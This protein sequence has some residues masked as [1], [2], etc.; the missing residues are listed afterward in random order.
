M[1]AH[2]DRLKYCDAHGLLKYASPTHIQPECEHFL[3]VPWEYLHVFKAGGTTVQSVFGG[4]TNCNS[5]NYNKVFA[6]VR[7]PVSH[8]LSGYHEAMMRLAE[9]QYINRHNPYDIHHYLYQ[10]SINNNLSNIDRMRRSLHY[11]S[12]HIELPRSYAEYHY[13]PAVSTLINDQYRIMPNLTS[14]IEIGQLNQ[15]FPNATLTH[16]RK[17][18]KLPQFYINSST[19]SPRDLFSICNYMILDYC[20]LNYTLP[21]Y[22]RGMYRRKHRSLSKNESVLWNCAMHK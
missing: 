15:L 11:S 12:S 2:L 21:Y 6:T 5:T 4:S 14:I 1:S 16:S 8:F 18:K 7:E 20:C 10:L 17:S 19:L 9:G 13:D 22:C 3:N